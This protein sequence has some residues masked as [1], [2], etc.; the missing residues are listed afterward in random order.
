MIIK[1]MS[2]FKIEISRILEDYCY[3]ERRILGIDYFRCYDLKLGFN[4]SVK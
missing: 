1:N 3:F 4:V 2:S